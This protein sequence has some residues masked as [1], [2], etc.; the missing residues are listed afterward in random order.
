[1]VREQ[2]TSDL[3]WLEQ[4]YGI[5]LGSTAD[6]DATEPLPDWREV[7]RLD[8]LLELPQDPQLIDQLRRRQLEA[9]VRE[10][11]R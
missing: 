2:H 9:V 5:V 3:E 6:A 1:L 8:D 4:H 11:L 7:S 10:G